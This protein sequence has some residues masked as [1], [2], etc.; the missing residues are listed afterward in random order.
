MHL[1]ERFES[2]LFVEMKYSKLN[3]YLGKSWRTCYERVD[4]LAMKEFTNLLWK[5]RGTCYSIIVLWKVVCWF[6]RVDTYQA[7]QCNLSHFGHIV[8]KLS[9]KWMSKGGAQRWFHNKPIMGK[10]LNIDRSNDWKLNKTKKLKNDG[11][12]GHSQAI[13]LKPLMSDILWRCFHNF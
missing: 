4:E 13:F 11:H 2:I 7:T 12:W 5:S 1:F 6:C 3:N 10:L 9:I 8:G